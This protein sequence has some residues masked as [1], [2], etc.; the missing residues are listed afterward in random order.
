MLTELS[1]WLRQQRQARDWATREMAR[2]LIRAAQAAQDTAIPSIDSMCTYIR[3]WEHGEHTITER[4]RLYYCTALNIPPAQF[5]IA[6]AGKSI[7]ADSRPPVS[8]AVTYRGMN[9]PYSGQFTVD[10]E[11]QM[12]AHESS[13]HAGQ[14]QPGLDATTAEQLR[15]DVVRLAWLINASEPL[16]PFLEMRR[17]RDRIYRLLDRRLTTREQA[18][19]Y[20]LL[21][22]LH[23]LMGTA[24]S[25]LGYIDAAEELVQAGLAYANAIDNRPLQGHL[26]VEL[27][28]YAR[29]RGRWQDSRAHA[30]AGLEY[31]R[32]GPGAADLY[33]RYAWA[34]A[35]A[36]DRDAA[37]R[38]VGA[39]QAARERD[40]TDDLLDIGG[41]FA[42]SLATHQLHVGSALARAEGGGREA[43]AETER[44]IELYDEGPR[45]G[46]QHWFAG[47]PLACID[48][49]L[50][51][52]R[53]GAVDAA[54]AALEPALSLPT[55]Q[56]II[57]ITNALASVRDELAAPIFRGSRQAR[58]LGERIEE[59]GR[60]PAML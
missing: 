49:A 39:A 15:A 57:D 12:T 46:E 38:A 18:E 27:S 59:F 22:C 5:G 48:L 2:R 28:A 44:A 35:A 1:C 53:S 41:E 34:A 11:T 9:G 21:G 3:R 30:V 32:E 60:A 47:K 45:E 36:G 56:R 4:Y 20:F 50:I 54:V 7:S 6:P 55:A 25:A 40:Y 24:A 58:E 16:G 51:R 37:R 13:A 10:R 43:E 31:L 14:T 19:L 8:T 33:L 26:R 17:V 29:W 42:L 23:E 52:L